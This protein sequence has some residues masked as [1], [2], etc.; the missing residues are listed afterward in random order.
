MVNP[1]SLAA[2]SI[3]SID[4]VTG[5]DAELDKRLGLYRVFLKLYEHHRNLL[6]EILDLENSSEQ[7]Q[8]RVTFQYVQGVVQGQ[9][10]HL[11]TNLLQGSTQAIQQPQQIWTIGRNRR[12]ALPIA[13]KRLSR[14]HAVIQY[15]PECGFYLV[16]LNSTNGSYVNGEQVRHR[17]LLKDGDRVRLGSLAF[18][19]F[20]GQGLQMADSV[21]S[22]V[23]RQLNTPASLPLESTSKLTVENATID[24]DTKLSGNREDTSMFLRPEIPA[25]PMT[26]PQQLS[27]AQQSDILDRFLKRQ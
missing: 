26:A 13:D 24:W 8:S 10:A 16:D 12:L 19:F 6:D 3:R 23:L 2:C 20:V 4:S 17:V 18:T 1:H 9:S 14:L 27:D 22:E 5:T 25:S 11:I 21:P 7:F 15:L